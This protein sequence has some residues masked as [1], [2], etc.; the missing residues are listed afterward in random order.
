[1]NLLDT[2]CGDL[3]DPRAVEE[4]DISALEDISRVSHAS[5]DMQDAITQQKLMPCFF[6]GRMRALCDPHAEQE[7]RTTRDGAGAET[8]SPF[9]DVLWKLVPERVEVRF[10]RGSPS[11][12][13]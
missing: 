3:L 12:S 8:A 9:V 1:M 6:C 10:L 2:P 11:P 7:E 4:V 13:R 5:S